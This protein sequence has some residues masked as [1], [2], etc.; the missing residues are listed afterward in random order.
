MSQPESSAGCIHDVINCLEKQALLVPTRMMEREDHCTIQD[1]IPS[2][3]RKKK[4]LK[5]LRALKVRFRTACLSTVCEEARCPN[6]TECFNAPTATFLILGDICTR[7]CRFCSIHK[8]KPSPP[9]RQEPGEVAQAAKDLRLDHVVITSVSRDDLVDQGAHAFAETISSI[10][11]ALPLSTIEVLTPDFSA[12]ASLAEIVFSQRPDVF[13]HNVETVSRLYPSVRPEASL[14]RSLNLL[15]MAHEHAEPLVVKS[16][17]MVGLGEKEDEIRD[18]IVS[19][20]QAGCDIIT[21]GQYMQPTKEQIPVVK[22]WHPDHFEEWS[23]LAKKIGI[24]YVISGPL[25]RSSYHAKE[26]LEG[27]RRNHGCDRDG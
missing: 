21:I 2:W 25:I 19:L 9:D 5:E 1:R 4:S 3:L 12:Q 15:R 18:L 13:N 11:A 27:I 17:F 24:S 7:G 22:Y 20:K 23:D 6:I 26:A 8:G 14:D 10:R 16:G